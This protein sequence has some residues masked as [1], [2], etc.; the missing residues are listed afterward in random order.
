MGLQDVY[1][2]AK[3]LELAR[4]RGIGQDMAIGS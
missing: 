4:A 2:G 3:I 1:V